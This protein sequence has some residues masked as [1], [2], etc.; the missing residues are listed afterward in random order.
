MSK[1]ISTTPLRDEF[2]KV[3]EFNAGDDREA[4][5]DIFDVF[6]CGANAALEAPCGHSSFVESLAAAMACKAEV[7]AYIKN[8]RRKEAEQN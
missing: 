3:W 5:E 1:P 2:E 6:M 8:K 4:I 7:D